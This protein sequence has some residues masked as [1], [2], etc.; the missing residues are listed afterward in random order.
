M[1]FLSP[2]FLAGLLALSL[3][4][5]LHLLERQAAERRSWSS[6]AFFRPSTQDSVRRRRYRYLALLACRLLLLA[7]L[8]FAFARPHVDARSALAPPPGRRHLVAVDTSLSMGHGDTW[9]RAQREAAAILGGLG[10]GDRSQLVAFGPEVHVLGGPTN[11][12]GSWRGPLAALAPTTARGSYGELGEA[13]RTLVAGD[14]APATLHVVS[15]FQRTA[16]PD[17]FADLGLPPGATLA[18]HDVGSPSRPNWCVEGMTGDRRLHGRA[19][20]DLQATI[21]GFDTPAAT[22]HVELRVGNRL[23]SSADV[24]VPASGRAV[25]RFP[26]VEL[27]R[28]LSRAEVRL[29]PLDALSADDVFFVAL[30]RADSLPVLF[31]RAAGDTRAEL[32]YR[33]ALASGGGGMFEL[34]ASTPE[35]AET[36]ALERF[37]FVVVHDVPR[38]PGLLEKRLRAFVESGRSALVVA[39]AAVARERT[40]PWT[41]GPL[42]EAPRAERVWRASALTPRVT[43]E[44][45]ADARVFRHLRLSAPPE[46]RLLDLDDGTPLLFEQPLGAG[47]LA[48]LTVP[49]D[50]AWTDLPVHVSFVPL[51]LSSARVLAGLD[52]TSGQETVGKRLDLGPP[53]DTPGSSVQ[54]L[55]PAGQRALSLRASVAERSVALERAGFYEVRRPGRTDEVA[56]N[57]DR[58]ESDLRPLDRDTLERW[59]ATGQGEARAASPSAAADP[60]NRRDLSPSILWWLVAAVLVEST[61]ANRYLRA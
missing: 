14:A 61:L 4:L 7:L 9:A 26:G 22:R 11:D 38:L 25:A 60:S 15:D 6:L 20:A 8:A 32:F 44:G 28:G 52:D 13:V 51:V 1:S 55:D 31:V 29:T 21:A 48:F 34:H 57:P 56:V 30:S 33:T 40:L 50:T 23:I 18:A 17:R 58:R 45:L 59:K 39:G 53:G 12:H 46:R 19:T 35:A 41:S 47:R 2:W 42:A 24:N 16:A 27:P 37:A 49:F 43:A 10:S 3:P 36:L 5:W 54:V